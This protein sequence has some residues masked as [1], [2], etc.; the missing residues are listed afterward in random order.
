MLTPIGMQVSLRARSLRLTQMAI[1][2]KLQ[3]AM[4]IAISAVQETLASTVVDVVARAGE[5]GSRAGNIR[6]SCLDT[7]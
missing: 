4:Y 7:T 6:D 1:Y 5:R 2:C 3:F